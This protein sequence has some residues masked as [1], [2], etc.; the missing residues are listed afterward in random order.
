MYN[1]VIIKVSKLY[2]ER[3]TDQNDV[4]FE[5]II[6]KEREKHMASEKIVPS[7]NNRRRYKQHNLKNVDFK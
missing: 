1:V 6:I 4:K 7:F 2:K 5:Q 3:T